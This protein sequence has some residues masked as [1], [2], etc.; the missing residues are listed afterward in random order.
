MNTVSASMVSILQTNFLSGFVTS[1][2]SPGT[3]FDAQASRNEFIA[4]RVSQSGLFLPINL[5]Q[6]SSKTCATSAKVPRF[7]FNM[8]TT[9]RKA[10]NCVTAFSMTV[11]K[12]IF[13]RRVLDLKQTTIVHRNLQLPQ[14]IECGR[15]YDQRLLWQLY[16]ED[17]FLEQTAGGIP[18]FLCQL[19]CGLIW[20]CVTE[21]NRNPQPSCTTTSLSNPSRPSLLW[22]LRKASAREH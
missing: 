18:T 10:L 13:T 12:G 14:K 9:S 17:M 5:D 16:I 2:I 11:T 22:P 7:A 1:S 6:S 15:K 21:G 19:V 8:S 3:A 20:T 4:G